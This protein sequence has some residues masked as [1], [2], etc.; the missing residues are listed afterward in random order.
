MIWQ[1]LVN[2]SYTASNGWLLQHRVSPSS[3]PVAGPLEVG[4]RWYP[5][6]IRWH[7]ALGL[8]ELGFEVHV[9]S[10]VV[11]LAPYSTQE[12]APCFARA[13]FPRFLWNVIALPRSQALPAPTKLNVTSN[14]Q[15][16]QCN[17][18]GTW[19][20]FLFL[21]GTILIHE[22]SSIIKTS[23]VYSTPWNIVHQI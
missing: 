2:H 4:T 14:W 12:V 11:L 13:K 16:G 15:F 20:S 19:Q 9:R 10:E 1:W 5:Q 17:F 8:G 6:T 18:G 3:W 22:A 7:E 21:G 23:T